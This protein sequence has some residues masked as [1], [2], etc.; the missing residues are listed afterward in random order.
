MAALV[1]DGR[2]SLPAPLMPTSW[3]GANEIAK[4]LGVSRSI[5]NWILREEGGEPDPDMARQG[6]LHMKG[7]ALEAYVNGRLKPNDLILTVGANGRPIPLSDG[8]LC[9][10]V[11]ETHSAKAT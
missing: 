3:I 2:W 1:R 9:L 6:I 10:R 11:N 7:A 4:L 5:A 8:L